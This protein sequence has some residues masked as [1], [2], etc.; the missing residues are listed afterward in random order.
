[1]QVAVIG[2][3]DFVTGFQLAGVKNTFIINEK[4]E[5]KIGEALEKQE[6]GVLVMD[7]A[8]LDKATHKTKK[9]LEKVVTPVIITLSLEGRESDLRSLIKKAVGVDLWK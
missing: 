9:A 8:D 1:M 2:T 7:Q 4:L 3:N 5:E 6:M